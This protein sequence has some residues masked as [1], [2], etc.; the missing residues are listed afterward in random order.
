M[1]HSLISSIGRFQVL[2]VGTINVKLWDS[3][4]FCFSSVGSELK[5]L[6]VLVECCSIELDLHP[7]YSDFDL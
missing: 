1:F 2:L 6:Y 3:F 4:C 7:S 5:T